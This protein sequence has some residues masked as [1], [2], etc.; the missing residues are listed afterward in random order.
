MQHSLVSTR[1][2]GDYP[3]PTS[4]F[5]RSPSFWASRSPAVECAI[6]PIAG[7]GRGSEPSRAQQVVPVD[8]V[9]LLPLFGEPDLGQHTARGGV[10]LPDRGPQ[11]FV[12][13]RSRPVQNRQRGL[14]GVSLTPN[15]AK[16]LERQFRFPIRSSFAIDQPAVAD[17][18]T[19]GLPLD[20]QQPDRRW[21]VT[22]DPIFKIYNR[23]C[24]SASIR[25]CGGT[26]GSR[27]VQS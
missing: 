9:Q 11:T 14:G 1:V 17:D 8:R 20:R 27:S 24:P 10:P 15:S 12:S 7:R 19:I 13:R 2:P 3:T 22:T 21:L 25:R 26:R 16:Q 6:S 18:V 4:D 5:S 23:G